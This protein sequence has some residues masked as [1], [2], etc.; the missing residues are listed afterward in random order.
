MPSGQHTIQ[1][2]DETWQ[3]KRIKFKLVE[4]KTASFKLPVRRRFGE[5]LVIG[6]TEGLTASAKGRKVRI[7]DGQS[8]LKIPP[9]KAKVT[10]QAPFHRT[11]R[12]FVRV[13][14]GR[15]VTIKCQLEAVSARLIVADGGQPGR[16][17]VDGKAIARVPAEVAIEPGDHEVVVEPDSQAHQPYKQKITVANKGVARVNPVY[18]AM[19]GGLEVNSRTGG[20]ER[21]SRRSTDR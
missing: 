11:I 8:V 20:S 12:R 16:L 18:S 19:V 14:R 13:R 21:L 4:H 3:S 2:L 5:V 7:K 6:S 1:I 17:L 15:K 10:C 9:G